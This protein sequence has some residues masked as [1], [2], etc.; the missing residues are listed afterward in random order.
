MVVSVDGY[1]NGP[2]GEF[3]S[4]AWSPD[5]DAWAAEAAGRFDTLLF[6]RAAWAEMA[7]YW[8]AAETDPGTPPPA[9]ALARF[10]NG[11]RK[12]VFSRTPQD[13]SAWTNS[14]LADA[15]VATVVAREKQRPGKDIAVFPGARF[16][17][18]ALAAGVVDEL[19]LLIVPELFGHGTRLF[20]GHAL[21]RRLT[22]KQTRTMDTGAVLAQYAV[23]PA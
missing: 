1:V 21:R 15:D 19:S 2:G 6:G 18:T 20:E 7:A 16:A 10:M 11:S 8:M 22:L 4:P 3:I 23:D 13:T 9:R 12:I 5:L 14:A 17:Q